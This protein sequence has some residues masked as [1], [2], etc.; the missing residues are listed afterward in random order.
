MEAFYSLLC[1]AAGIVPNVTEDGDGSWNERE[2]YNASMKKVLLFGCLVVVL[3]IA[4]FIII[5][6]YRKKSAKKKPVS[7]SSK[8]PLGGSGTKRPTQ[9]GME[10]DV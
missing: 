2:E 10:D 5:K 8:K 4:L 9:T 7:N 1:N 3:V 6:W